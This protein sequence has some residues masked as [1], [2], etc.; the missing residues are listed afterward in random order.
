MPIS[1]EVAIVGRGVTRF[2]ELYDRSYISLVHEASMLALDDAGVSLGQI[3]AAWL[4]T[5]EPYL[6]AL[7]GD[8]GGA[9]AEALGV[10]IPAT[11]V[12]NFCAT[13]MESVRAAA[14]AVAA[15]EYDVVLAVGA[16]KMRDLTP[17]ESLVAKI[18]EQSHPVLAKGRTAAGGFALV[19]RRY[20]EEFGY[21]REIMTAVAVKNHEHATRNP[22]AHYRTVV[23][24]KQVLASAPVAEP[25]NVLDCTPTTDGAAAVI[26]TSRRWAEEH[27][28]QYAL[29]E[30]IGTATNGG[31]YNAFFRSD[32]DFL[33]FSVTRTAAQSAYAQAGIVDPLSEIDVVE[34]H[35]CFTITEVVNTE[36]LGLFPRGKGGAALL[37][38]RTRHDGDMPVNVSGGLQSCGHPIG[39]TGVRMV[40]EIMDQVLGRS[41]RRQVPGAR[42]GIAHNLGGPGVV[43]VVTV[44][45][46]P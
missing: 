29:I 15:G 17:K 30:G 3:E 43:A 16:E 40:A 14:L 1:N 10:S 9:I 2:G 4:G 37:E 28:R 6:G 42:R 36:D 13:G 11:R 45:R 38:G 34:C 8:S 32:N 35:D 18:V 12:A 39:A 7:V 27:A 22:K 19:A 24:E 20:M 33:G 26:V 5:A 25:L 23:T 46:R 41:D 31:Y 21:G 44:L